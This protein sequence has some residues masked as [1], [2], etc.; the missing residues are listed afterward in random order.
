MQKKKKIK[1]RIRFRFD[2]LLVRGYV[3]RNRPSA[4]KSIYPV[5][6]A[7]CNKNGEAYP[8]EKTIAKLSGR[9]EKTVRKGLK[10][11]L[12]FPHF[13]IDHYTTNKGHRAKKYSVRFPKY[14]RGRTFD[15][16]RAIIDSGAW[17]ELS[18]CAQALYPVMRTF[19]FWDYYEYLGYLDIDPLLSG[20]KELFRDRDYDLVNKSKSDLAYYSGIS[21][22]SLYRAMADMENH[23]LI[24]RTTYFDKEAWR[25]YLVPWGI[26]EDEIQ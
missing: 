7:H 22:T 26:L 1:P 17:A 19:G 5:I 11:L 16:C 3:W 24:E 2:K 18:P 23:E 13:T 9:D 14:E 6:C 8:S 4:S 25:I 12:K 20:E 10:G 15:F 21:R